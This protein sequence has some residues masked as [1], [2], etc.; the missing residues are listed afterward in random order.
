MTSAEFALLGQN[1]NLIIINNA[2]SIDEYLYT[3]I[4]TC[5]SELLIMSVT[6]TLIYP[7]SFINKIL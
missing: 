4:N 5:F 1:Y 2:H 7:D 3:I 6:N